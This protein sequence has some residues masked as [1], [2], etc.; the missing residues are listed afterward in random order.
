MT[1]GCKASMRVIATLPKQCVLHIIRKLLYTGF[2]SLNNALVQ[3]RTTDESKKLSR[4]T[5]DYSWRGEWAGVARDITAAPISRDQT[6]GH[7][8]E[9]G[10]QKFP[11]FS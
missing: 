10:K 5:A 1:Q 9:K 8:R 3:S 4:S 11:P 2:Y 6:L 7:E